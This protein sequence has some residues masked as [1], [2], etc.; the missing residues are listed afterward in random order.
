MVIFWPFLILFSENKV[1]HDL[2]GI[3]PVNLIYC[4]STSADYFS[5]NSLKRA[6]TGKKGHFWPV[7]DPFWPFLCIFRKNKVPHDTLVVR[8]VNLIYYTSKSVEPFRRRIAIY[9]YIHISIY[10]KNYIYIDISKMICSNVFCKLD[11]HWITA[12]LMTCILFFI[13]L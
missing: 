10:T 6:E 13:I 11:F 1:A 12:I 2:P 3:L 9:I 5:R 7:F 8:P 4:T